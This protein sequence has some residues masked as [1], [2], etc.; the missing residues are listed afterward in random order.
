MLAAVEQREELPLQLRHPSW[1]NV[2]FRRQ[3]VE[4]LVHVVGEHLADVA[5]ARL[6]AENPLH[7]LDQ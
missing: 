7:D 6:A 5:G 3:P 4:E 1:I 2:G